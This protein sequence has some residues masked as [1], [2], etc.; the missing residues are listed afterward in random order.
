MTKEKA[1]SGAR[2][3]PKRGMG[4]AHVYRTL[5]D[6]ILDLRLAP[7]S[8]V[9]ESQLAE[10]FAMSRTPI[11]EALVRLSVEGLITTLPNRTTIVSHIDL[12][13]L[14]H[15]FDALTLMYRV[16][17]RLAASRRSEADIARMRERQSAFTRA[18]A[19]E[20]ALALIASNRDFHLEIAVAGG[21]VYYT[22]LFKRLLDENRRLLR[23]Y[24]STFNDALPRQYVEEHDA[25]IAA[26]IAGDVA[27]A[28]R[29]ATAHAEQIIRQIQAYFTHDRRINAE[30]AL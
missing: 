14:P 28:D 21:N 29:L 24:Y 1:Q 15:F 5:R 19:A 30:I 6:E 10:R 3:A 20:D 25:M 12:L 26:I 17:T 18:V 27:A 2:E 13:N 23:L 11:R 8:P 16:T 22:E 7:G 9:D 4:V